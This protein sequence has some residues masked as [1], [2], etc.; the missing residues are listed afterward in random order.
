MSLAALIEQY[1]AGPMILRQAVAGM[2]REQVLARPIEGKWS[3][4]EVI[5]HLSDF[6]IVYVDR[7]TAIIAETDPTLPGRDEQKY[8]ARLA[9]QQRDLEEELRLFEACRTRTARILRTLTEG[10][11]TRRGIHT[12]AGP[13]T[14]AQMLDRVVDHVQ[15]HVKF[16]HEKR[17]ALGI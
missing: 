2:S 16:I 10:D 17:K 12:E 1:A 15:H 9:Y 8:A 6:E 5:C 3:T 13:L 14:L 7:L 4:L 11:L